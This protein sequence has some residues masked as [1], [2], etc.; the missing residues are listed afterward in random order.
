M[1][2]QDSIPQFTELPAKRRKSSASEHEPKRRQLSA[3]AE[4]SPSL[5]SQRRRPSSPGSTQDQP[6]ERKPARRAGREEDRKRGQRLFGALLGTLSQSSTTAAQKRR[7]DIEKRQQAKLKSQAE[8]YDELK[9]RRKERRELIR[10]KETPF[11][12]REA[13]CYSLSLHC[14][15][16]NALLILAEF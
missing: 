14:N 12:T 15:W 7:A 10:E 11:L 3:Q 8:E 6:I 9:K 16:L 1:P 13:V 2:D 4:L 5:Q